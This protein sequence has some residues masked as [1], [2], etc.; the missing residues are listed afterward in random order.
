VGSLTQLTLACFLALQSDAVVSSVADRMKIDKAD[1]LGAD[2]SNAAV[3]LA[4][5]ETHVIQET[6]D[7]LQSEGVDLTLPSSTPRSPTTL[8]IKNIPYATGSAALAEM[9]EPF[10][11]VARL[12]VPPSRTIAL[13]EFKDAREA[14]EAWKGLSYKRVGNSVLYLEKGPKGLWDGEVVEKKAPELPAAA[15]SAVAPSTVD[16]PASA[17]KKAPKAVPATTAKAADSEDVP[18]NATLF[19]KNLSF[20]TTPVGLLSLFSPLPGFAFCRIQTKPQPTATNP[21][22][23]VSM[24][25]G[26]AGFKTPAQAEA[27]MKVA[28]GKV[29]DGRALEVGFAKRNTEDVEVG[30]AADKKGGK[31]GWMETTTKMVVKN[32]PFEA[33]KKDVQ[34]LFGY[35]LPS[36]S[37][38]ALPIANAPLPFTL[39]QLVCTAQVGPAAQ[40]VQRRLARFRLPRLPHPARGRVGHGLAQAHPSARPAP[41][42]RVG[43]GGR[44]RR[45]AARAGRRRRPGGRGGRRREA[46]Q[47]DKDCSLEALLCMTPLSP[48]C[49]PFCLVSFDLSRPGSELER[50]ARPAPPPPPPTSSASVLLLHHHRPTRPACLSQPLPL[51][52]SWPC[53]LPWRADRVSASSPL[54]SIQVTRRLLSSPPPLTSLRGAARRPPPPRPGHSP[55]SH[56]LCG[57]SRRPLQ[58]IAPRLIG[59]HQT[60]SWPIGPCRPT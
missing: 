25:F 42:A 3:K 58:H 39:P 49:R 2:S 11:E 44:G 31:K 40:E 51:L 12:L 8:L 52:P 34:E 14:R 33:S 27:A 26:F 32:L 60:P 5:A 36:C 56:R 19:V 35:A 6:K 24:G 43:Q 23:R 20:A 29:I 50:A 59:P 15:A 41:R 48:A 18:P 47:A 7:Y 13:V 16:L 10:G 30:P 46:G 4:L 17:A 57:P 38:P 55:A 37:A 54:A 22:Q 53:G 1:I 28:Q 45:Q 21:T 9:L